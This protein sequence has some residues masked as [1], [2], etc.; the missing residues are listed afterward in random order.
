[1]IVF[2]TKNIDKEK[3]KDI[4]QRTIILNGDDG[5]PLS[6]Y[7]A[8][9]NFDQTWTLMIIPV[10]EQGEYKRY[11]GHLQVEVSDGIAWGVT[12]QK[13]IYMFINDSANS[14]IIRQNVMPLAHELLHALYIDA[15]GTQHI[16]RRYNA[17]EGK[18]GTSGS[19]ATVIVHD[20]WYGSKETIKIWIRWGF[21]WMPIT[22]PYIP[23]KKAKEIYDIN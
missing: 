11:Y 13:V 16:V 17:P 21:I 3:Y 9:Q 6:G 14:F 15:V 4:I 8:W 22:I 18:A 7:R 12:G 10:T 20:N 1:M 19:R 23:I 5:T 2:K